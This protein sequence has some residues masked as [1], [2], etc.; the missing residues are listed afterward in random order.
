[1]N[2]VD[3]L[4]GGWHAE[5]V[6]LVA[7]AAAAIVY[8]AGWRRLGAEASSLTPSRTQQAGLAAG[9]GLILVAL[10]SPLDSLALQLQWVHMV[11]HVVLLVVAPPL[12]VLARPWETA[13][14][15][16]GPRVRRLLSAPVAAATTHARLCGAAAT[17]VVLFVGVLWL[18]H[19]PALYDATLRND[20][21][22]NLEHC[23][24]LLT[25]LLF[26]TAAL[27]RRT[28]ACSLGVVAR[29][30]TVLGGMVGSWL[31]AVYIGY[32]PGVLYA[33]SGSGGLSALADQQVAAG[34]MW[35]PASIPFIAVLVWIVARWLESDARDAT[36]AGAAA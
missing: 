9:I 12:V 21:V 15:A 4:F 3:A 34:V 11:Q 6:P 18:W 32:A 29:S 24:F 14:A 7:A 1:M 35:V 19:I 27:P 26:W 33:Y 20:A 28:V 2:V 36:A 10:L 13:A 5:P 17:A 16:F 22:H 30:V 25:G 23:T 8:H 31:L